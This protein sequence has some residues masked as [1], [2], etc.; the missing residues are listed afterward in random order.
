MICVQLNY[1]REI[2]FPIH[3]NSKLKN[4]SHNELNNIEIICNGTG[5]HC[6]LF[7]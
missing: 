3:L 5:L 1:K 6:P 2:R 4:A 7:R